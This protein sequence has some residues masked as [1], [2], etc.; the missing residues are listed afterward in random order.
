M[1]YLHY[2]PLPNALAYFAEGLYNIGPSLQ[3]FS[4]EMNKN[5]YSTGPFLFSMMS[6]IVSVVSVHWGDCVCICV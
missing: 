1:G 3:L 6:V 4:D 2:M 5:S